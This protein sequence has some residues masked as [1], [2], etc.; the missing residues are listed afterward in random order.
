M[1]EE[2]SAHGRSK[3]KCQLVKPVTVVM[4]VVFNPCCGLG[5]LGDYGLGG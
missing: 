2:N 1:S 3:T 4:Y 5:R